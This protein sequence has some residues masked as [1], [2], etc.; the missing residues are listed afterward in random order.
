[1]SLGILELSAMQGA[2]LTMADGDVQ[3]FPEHGLRLFVLFCREA[4]L[5]D[6]FPHSNRT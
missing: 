2:G 1:M 5:P 6:P 4:V 3:I